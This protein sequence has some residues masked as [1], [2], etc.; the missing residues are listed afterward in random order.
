M[1]NRVPRN[2]TTASMA[3]DITGVFMLMLWIAATLT[4]PEV[5]SSVLL[6]SV[7]VLL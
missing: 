6:S 4:T 1:R 7:R 5:R 2:T 3:D